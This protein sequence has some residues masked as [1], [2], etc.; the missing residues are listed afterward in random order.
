MALELDLNRQFCSQIVPSCDVILKRCN[1][2]QRL[3]AVGARRKRKNRVFARR[4]AADT[5]PSLSSCA[6]DRHRTIVDFAEKSSDFEKGAAKSAAI[7]PEL[8]ELLRRWEKLP[9]VLKSTI[10]AVAR[11]ELP[12]DA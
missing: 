6:Q 7:D 10:L 3:R 2:F 8:S 12:T 1:S 4:N 9:R 5:V 11:Q